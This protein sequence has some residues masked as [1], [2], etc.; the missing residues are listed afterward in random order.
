MPTKLNPLSLTL[1]A[2]L[3]GPAVRE[4]TSLL[5]AYPNSCSDSACQQDLHTGNRLFN[6]HDQVKLSLS[7]AR[8]EYDLICRIDDGLRGLVWIGKLV[9]RLVMVYKSNESSSLDFRKSIQ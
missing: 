1:R 5:H 6:K 8:A 4:Q 3:S 7:S 2:G 9:D